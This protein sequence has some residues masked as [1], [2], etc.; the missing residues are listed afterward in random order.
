MIYGRTGNEVKI[1]RLAKLED[2]PKLDNRKADKQDRE[3]IKINYLVIVECFAKERLYDLAFLRADGG[4]KEIAD[5]VQRV[6]GVRP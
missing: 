3:R 4:I 6:T 5:E 2:V 1:L